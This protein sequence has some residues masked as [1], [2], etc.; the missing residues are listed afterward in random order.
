M[1]SVDQGS[2]QETPVANDAHGQESSGGGA[3]GS[4]PPW[5][6]L[7]VEEALRRAETDAGRGLSTQEAALRL[8]RLGPNALPEGV[9]KSIA[10]VFLH[11]FKSPLI[12]LLIAAA[13]IALALGKVSDS[14]VILVVVLINA[15]IGTLQEGRAERSLDALRRLAS[16][17][18]HVLRDGQEQQID[19]R[20]LVRGDL[21][22][23]AAGDAVAADARLVEGAGLQLSEAALTGESAPVAKEPSPL[24][25]E[26]V[27]A[28][29]KNMLYA[30]TYVTAGRARAVVVATGPG[31]EIGRIAA[32]AE[33]AEEPKTPLERRIEQFGR[34]IM[35]A[36]LVLLIT[37]VTIGTLRGVPFGQIAM[38]GISQV[39][40]MVP[41]GLPVAITIALAVGVQRMAKRRSV[42]RRLAA[43][44]TLG[45][46]TVICSDKTGTLTRN[47]MT[48]TTVH[49]PGG[50]EFSVSGVGYAPEGD[51]LEK[52]GQV[53]PLAEEDLRGLLE[54]A[55]LCN[56][57]QLVGPE[58]QEP[59]WKP[60]G[61][62]TEVA[63]V[64]LGKKAGL[65][66]EEVR[67]H[68]PRQAE[69]PFDAATKMMATQHAG[70]ESTWVVLKGAPEVL[71]ELCGGSRQGGVVIPMDERG[72][73]EAH[74]AAE[75]MAH[76]A[77][78]VLAIAI[79]PGASIDDRADPS[80]FRGKAIWLGLVG[81]MDPPRPEVADAVAR[82]RAAGIR[83]VIVTGDHKVTGLAVARAL[84]IAREGDIAVDGRELEQLSDEALAERIDRISVFARVHP[85]Q[86]LRIVRAY[87]RRHEVV[88]M[89]GDGVND[90]PAL[91]QADVGIA[92][93][94]TGTEVAK[95]ASKMVIADDNFSTIVAAVE[96]GRVVYRNL[97]KVILYLFSTSMAEVAVL[98]AAL[99]MGYPPP[100]AAVQILWINLV[101][102][103]VVTINLILDPAEGDEMRRRPIPTDEPLLTRT[104]L[105]RMA[106]M[107]PAIAISTLGWF[108]YRL[109][110]GAPFAQVQTET[111]TVLAVCQW[112]NV[113]NC[114]S[115]GRS[116]FRMNL[117]KNP[118]LIGGLVL[119]NLLQAMVVFLPF[120]NEIFHT[121]PFS[122]KE[123]V[124]IGVVA[125]FVLWV[126]ELRKLLVRRRERG[127]S[128]RAPPARTHG[129]EERAH[130]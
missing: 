88:A 79:V 17:K 7:R 34:Y 57:A 1:R 82:C 58:A 83:P 41:E 40:G 73:Q 126:E 118:W 129:A 20:E 130:A 67:S 50:R 45:S 104:L 65:A 71:L 61:D 35:G 96:E 15:L 90:A 74:A 122:L 128:L 112:F 54:A 86:K 49:L 91:A 110:T 12:Y 109:S 64:T 28:D 27:L 51:F 44:E 23:L 19:A 39:V 26:T 119:G 62:P 70:P 87:Q 69:I 98:L 47:E 95:E 92:M 31:S 25:P 75:S 6:A 8:A 3:A 38:V 89:T 52:G 43:V 117:L 68:F 99:V 115:E 48:V 127:E 108:I 76:R 113:L 33:A 114:R 105:S 59:R 42:V 107:T 93:G 53:R 36:A 103:G 16:P 106:F 111:F 60:M 77:L 18:A 11:Q 4:E 78:R 80:A 55:V 29:R 22:L 81:Q 66:L 5:H 37:V 101:T 85:A 30:G 13:G 125:S 21:L 120:M 84:G 63:L 56:D 124:A 14:A 100:L 72:R 10:T 24:G 46:T 97:K 94:V 32:L 9:R 2:S 123:V 121:V 116:V 102:E